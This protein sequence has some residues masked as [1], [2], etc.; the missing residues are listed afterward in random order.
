MRQKMAWFMA[1]LLVAAM[2][3][4]VSATSYTKQHEVNTYTVYVNG[5]KIPVIVRNGM[6]QIPSTPG[7]DRKE[8]F[9]AVN[10]YFSLKHKLSPETSSQWTGSN[11]DYEQRKAFSIPHQGDVYISAYAYLTIEKD[12]FSVVA[13][14]GYSSAACWIQPYDY[15]WSQDYPAEDLTLSV[16]L[17]FGTASGS[18]YISVPPGVGFSA[19]SEGAEYSVTLHNTDYA[20]VDFDNIQASSTFGVYSVADHTT[21]AFYFGEVGHNTLYIEG[22]NV[23]KQRG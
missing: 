16:N 20:G 10:R 18:V 2:F 23:Y 5:Q 22:A 19:T 6:I 12:Q 9:M 7:I 4:G 15:W 11:S 17:R 21:G 3:Q 8:V 1:L 13:V 14:G